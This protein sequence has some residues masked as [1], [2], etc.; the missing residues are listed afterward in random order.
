MNL[1]QGIHAPESGSIKL[2]G[3]IMAEQIGAQIFIDGFGLVSPGDPE[4]A[5][6]LAKKA[7]SVSHDGESIYGA[8]VV[9]AI[10]AYSF[11]ETD[12]KKIIEESKKFI[13]KESEIFK[14]ISDIQNWSSGNIDWEQARIKI[15]EKYGYSKFPMNPH[16]VPNHALIILSL[17]FGDDNFQKSLMIANTAG[18]DTDCN[19]GNVGCILGI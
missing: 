3:K 15:D 8:Q 18:W 2:N 16:I 7:G 14:L 19:S 6:E 13:P 5:V 9:A 11:I 12:I 10:E 17:L 4:L 1:K